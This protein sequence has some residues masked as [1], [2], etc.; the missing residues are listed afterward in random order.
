MSANCGSFFA[1]YVATNPPSTLPFATARSTHTGEQPSKR[2][3]TN[4]DV[5]I[6]TPQPTMQPKQAMAYRQDF[7]SVLAQ[8]TGEVAGM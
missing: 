6:A 1:E 3:M 7:E 2:K 5:L 8:E 4:Y